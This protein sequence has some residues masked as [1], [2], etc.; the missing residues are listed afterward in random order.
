MDFAKAIE[1]ADISMAPTIISKRNSTF[2]QTQTDVDASESVFRKKDKTSVSEH[3][4]KKKKNQAW[5]LIGGGITALVAV[6]SIASFVIFKST[7]ELVTIKNIQN[8][9]TNAV[10]S[11]S[12]KTVGISSTGKTI[13]N[14]EVS[15]SI[16]DT[17][18]INISKIKSIKPKVV[19]GPSTSAIP[20]EP[21]TDSNPTTLL[22]KPESVKL[23][24]EAEKST[25]E[26]SKY[27]SHC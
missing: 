15:P 16:E 22:I 6:I 2:N 19:E 10:K 24:P 14:I 23:N 21:I 9:P 20:V 12:K 11:P 3:F 25:I 17:V 8:A 7:K 18:N 4:K 27:D 26:S 5:L 13:S 1:T